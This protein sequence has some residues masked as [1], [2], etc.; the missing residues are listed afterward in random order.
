MRMTNISTENHVANKYKKIAWKPI[1]DQ[2]MIKN[3]SINSKNFFLKFKNLG[4]KGLYQNLES[5]SK[6][7]PIYCKWKKYSTKQTSRT[8]TSS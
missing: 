2:D 6:G 7:F 8:I 3:I 1:T 4:Y 5:T